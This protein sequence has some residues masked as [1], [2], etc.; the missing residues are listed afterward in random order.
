MVTGMLPWKADNL[1]QMRIKTSVGRF[2]F[3]NVKL[4]PELCKAIHVMLEQPILANSSSQQDPSTSM[5]QSFVAE[6]PSIGSTGMMQ[7]TKFF[8]AATI[9]RKV[10]MDRLSRICT[11]D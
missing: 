7:W 10:W 1:E 4:K 11:H 6:L 9:F 2:S 3:E 5:M 8:P